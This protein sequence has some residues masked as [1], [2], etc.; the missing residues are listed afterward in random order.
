MT[1]YNIDITMKR[2]EHATP[3]SP[4]AVFRADVQD[5]VDSVFANTVVSQR[6]IEANDPKLIGVF[7]RESDPAVVREKLQ[8]AANRRPGQ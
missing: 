1:Y 6:K 7:D 2:I 5:M 8:R 4:I 3:E